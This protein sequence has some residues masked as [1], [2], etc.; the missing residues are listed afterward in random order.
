MGAPETGPGHR[1]EAH[2]PGAR[3]VGHRKWSLGPPWWPPC[4]G[5]ARGSCSEGAWALGWGAA[6]AWRLAPSPGRQSSLGLGG[7]RASEAALALA[8]ALA[9]AL[10]HAHAHGWGPAGDHRGQL[11][12]CCHWL[13]RQ[14][15]APV[16]PSCPAQRWH[17]EPGDPVPKG[18][19][20]QQRPEVPVQKGRAPP[21]TREP[22]QKEPWARVRKAA[23]RVSR[24]LSRGLPDPPLREEGRGA[25][26]SGPPG[27]CA[28]RLGLLSPRGSGPLTAAMGRNGP[29]FHSAPAL[30]ASTPC[31]PLPP[32][33]GVVWMPEDAA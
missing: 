13:Q 8:L 26:P 16:T 3:P 21:G 30:Q 20:A 29:G 1:D 12:F 6:G 10:T 7:P 19:E 27:P 28:C 14:R 22:P 2:G 33:P 9:H 17:G 23:P 32:S 24:I 4:L 31:L 25:E 15:R 5:G 18:P 11:G